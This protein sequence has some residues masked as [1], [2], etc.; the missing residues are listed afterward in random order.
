MQN[1][2]KVI[3]VFP[4]C[5]HYRRPD[6]SQEVPCRQREFLS[7]DPK[8]SLHVETCSFFRNDPEKTSRP[9][10]GNPAFPSVRQASNKARE[11]CRLP[12]PRPC[13]GSSRLSNPLSSL[14][15]W[16]SNRSVSAH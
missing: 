2:I 11:S 9:A 13:R 16:D 10:A 7:G 1:G 14:C 3:P 15:P 12:P 4:E 6:H 8:E 5:S